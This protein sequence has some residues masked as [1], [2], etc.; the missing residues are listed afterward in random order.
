MK[1]QAAF[2]AA[3]FA[4]AEFPVSVGLFPAMAVK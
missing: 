1:N 3:F 4:P 2:R